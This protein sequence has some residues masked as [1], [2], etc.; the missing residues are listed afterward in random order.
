[1][2]LV[3]GLIFPGI[4]HGAADHWAALKQ[5]R[6]RLSFLTGFVV[7]YLLAMLAVLLLWLVH[8]LFGLIFFLACSA[9]HFGQ[10]DMQEWDA[11]APLRASSWGVTVLAVILLGHWPETAFIIEAY[12]IDLPT[13]YE[14]EI[15]VWG[16]SLS[17]LLAILHGLF[18]KNAARKKWVFVLAI[19]LLGLLLPLL[20][21][22]ALYFIGSHSSKGWLHLKE[23]FK[24][25][26]LQLLQRTAPFS[27][28]A[29][30]LG[31]LAYWLSGYYNLSPD[32]LWPWLFTFIAIISAPHIL[33]MHRLYGRKP[34]SQSALPRSV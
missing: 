19:L 3:L 24:V 6:M 2:L 32:N 7:L 31:G 20:L 8:P 4:P 15:H 30:L 11:Y 29:F 27:I 12:G 9:W 34:I 18:L 33:I 22:F 21:S 23:Q 25:G 26:N 17:A 1:M 16:S 10:T 28:G 5:E 13:S 14:N